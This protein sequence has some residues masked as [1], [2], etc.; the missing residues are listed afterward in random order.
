MEI[1][2]NEN[3]N[4]NNNNNNQPLNF[5]LPKPISWYFLIFS[6]YLRMPFDLL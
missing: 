6:S 4:N 3:N 1:V 2:N 5:D